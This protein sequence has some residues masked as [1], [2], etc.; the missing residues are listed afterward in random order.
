[1]T[2]RRPGRMAWRK[3]SRSGGPTKDCVEVAVGEASV[4]VR[5]SKNVT[6]PVL[7]FPRRN[8]NA[9]LAAA[10]ADRLR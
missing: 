10:K 2:T 7:D 6:G 4:G 1:M 3:S 5:D 9:F 8:W